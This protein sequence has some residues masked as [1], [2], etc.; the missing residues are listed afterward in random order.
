MK[1]FVVIGMGRFGTAVAKKLTELGH[2]VLAVDKEEHNIQGVTDIVTHA[3]IADAT[4]ER[5]LKALGLRNYDC[6]ILAI[7][8]N[9]ADSV[10]TA[11][12][13]KEMGIKE[14]ICKARDVQHKKILLKVG[15]DY[16]IIP[17]VEAGAKLAIRLADL[18]LIEF[19][20]LDNNFGVSEM[21]VPGRWV[22]KSIQQIHVRQKYGSTIVA[23]KRRQSEDDI[24]VA[25]G[26]DYIFAEGD[27]LVLVGESEAASLLGQLK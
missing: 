11:L 25:P 26:A 20:E 24:I 17:E 15:A 13:L 1:S 14:I 5:N 12:A 21:Y 10:L 9:L 19:T 23:I 8:D 4:E 16:V 7:G 3:V 22:G 27:I 2:E 6:A 18:N